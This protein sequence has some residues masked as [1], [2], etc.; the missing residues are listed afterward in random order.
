MR[1]LVLVASGLLVGLACGSFDSGSCGP[2]AP[3]V[4]GSYS[5]AGDG[6]WSDSA[7][8]F[9][10]DNRQ[11]KAMQLVLEADRVRIN[12]VSAGRQIVE[13]WKPGPDRF[14]WPLLRDGGAADF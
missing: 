7:G 9:P 11:P 1:N 13:I 8:T 3:L 10:H 6:R 4:S 12:Y 5:S 2:A 14:D